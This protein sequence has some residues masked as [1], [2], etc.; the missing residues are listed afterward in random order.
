MKDTFYESK[1]DP[2]IIARPLGL[3]L[4]R[5]ENNRLW[6]N[7]ADLIPLRTD[8]GRPISKGWFGRGRT[9]T[10][11]VTQAL[12]FLAREH[13]CFGFRTGLQAD[14]S[15]V[16]VADCDVK[17]GIDGIGNF[18]QHMGWD[19]ESMASDPPMGLPLSTPSGGVHFYFHVWPDAPAQEVDY[20]NRQGFLPGVDIRGRGGFTRLYCNL[21]LV[22]DVVMPDAPARH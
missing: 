20:G 18:L 4:P 10:M 15:F 21:R 2:F 9:K 22:S 14:G 3:E 1:G 16:L 6:V 17:H 12:N 11:N 5:W 8:N 19:A 13:V 7:V